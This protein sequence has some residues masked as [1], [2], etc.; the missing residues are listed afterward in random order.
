MNTY[1][2]NVIFYAGSDDTNDVDRGLYAISCDK[3][4]SVNEMKDIFR[5]V[6]GLLSPYSEE[7]DFPFS[8]D[9]GLNIDT[10]IEGVRVHTGYPVVEMAENC[11]KIVIDDYYTIEQWQ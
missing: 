1:L 2:L 10:L 6:N 11:G 4:V 8:Y 3:T 7:D 9:E 5:T